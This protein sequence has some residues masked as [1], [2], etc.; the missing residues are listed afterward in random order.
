RAA[1][2]RDRHGRGCASLP[3]RARVPARGHGRGE[4]G[5]AATVDADD[6]G[7]RR[8]RHRRLAR[9]AT[10]QDALLERVQA[11]RSVVGRAAALL[12]RW[13]VAALVADGVALGLYYGFHASLPDTST[14][15]DV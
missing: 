5:R 10:R 7:A 4:A 3:E 11:T 14:W 1:E 6:R 12:T 15:G 13:R 8:P 2:A 9:R